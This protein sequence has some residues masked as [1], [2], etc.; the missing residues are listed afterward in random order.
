MGNQLQVLKST[1]SNDSVKQRFNEILGQKAPG[2]I[3][4][5]ISVAS[6]NS[7]LQN[8]EPQSI[9]NAAV[10]AA[11]LDL[12]INPN[13]GFAAIVPYKGSAQFQ[14][15]YKGLIELCLRSGQ[16]LS[17]IDN[18]VYEGELVSKNRFTGDYIFDESL[19]S[20]DKIIGYMAY[21]KLINGFEKTSYMNIDEVKKHAKR[22]S[23][24]YK[25]GYGV[26]KDDFDVMARKTV[27]KL[28]LAKYAPKSIEMQ[29]AIIFDQ[30][31]IKGDLT[32]SN[33][34]DADI[35]YIDNDA[36]EKL[37]DIASIAAGQSTDNLFDD[38]ST[39]NA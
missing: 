16:F 25:S 21:F 7:Y 17:I 10:V 22:F 39:E 15:M 34:D 18:V 20:S 11:T 1:L 32:D 8:V 4:S 3:S 33:I 30:S 35:T 19:R 26:W 23:Q 27:L 31:T 14:L 29:R 2:F 9:L 28:L 38:G 36:K 12:P 24:S 6:N 37:N 5:I 13:L